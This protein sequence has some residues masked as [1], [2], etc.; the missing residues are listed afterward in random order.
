MALSDSSDVLI[1]FSSVAELCVVFVPCGG[2]NDGQVE[3]ELCV[4]LYALKL[5]K[6]SAADVC[7]DG[8]E[9]ARAKSDA[10]EIRLS[11][12]FPST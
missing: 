7:H 1:R 11:L 9:S 10:M 8:K 4:G 6:K 5:W 2:R 3:S 12:K